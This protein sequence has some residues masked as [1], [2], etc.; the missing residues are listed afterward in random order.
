MD[1]REWLR[2]QAHSY[3]FMA[4]GAMDGDIDLRPMEV[5]SVHDCIQ[6]LALLK[7]AEFQVYPHRDNSIHVHAPHRHVE[8]SWDTRGW[9]CPW[10]TSVKGCEIAHVQ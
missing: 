2:D 4:Y 9:D 8:H 10:G 7:D 3:R 5:A 1:T 6:L